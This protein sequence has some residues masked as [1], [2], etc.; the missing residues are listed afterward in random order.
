MY[1]ETVNVGKA[2]VQECTLANFGL[3]TVNTEKYKGVALDIEFKVGESS[4]RIRKFPVNRVQVQSDMD[5]YP[6]RFKNKK[7]GA[8]QTIDEVIS[9]KQ[10]DLSS[11]VK[12]VVTGFVT[13]EIWSK[14]ISEWLETN[15]FQTGVHE[16]TFEQFVAFAQSLLPVNYQ[17]IAG[18]V[19]V[20]Y[21]GNTA[22]LEVPD[23]MYIM[24]DF[25]STPLNP[26]EV[27]VPDTK[28]FKVKQWDKGNGSAPAAV[29]PTTSVMDY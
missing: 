21:K 1:G 29:N 9:R 20:G 19:A 28:Y 15:K 10:R 24:G 8:M 3:A 16:P 7:T 13:D 12:H 4:Y 23:D 2:G 18:M 22:Y 5:K 11:Y 6:E 25:F 17:S 27:A 26:K 14:K